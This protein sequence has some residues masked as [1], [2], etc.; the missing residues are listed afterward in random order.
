[1]IFSVRL[2]F[3]VPQGLPTPLPTPA[4]TIDSD[5]NPNKASPEYVPLVGAVRLNVAVFPVPIVE[6]LVI[7]RVTPVQLMVKAFPAVTV[8]ALKT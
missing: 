4:G 7:T 3:G 2:L 5:P 6:L 1:M 8:A